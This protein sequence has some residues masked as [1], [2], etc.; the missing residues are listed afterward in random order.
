M[1]PV[2]KIASRY[3]LRFLDKSKLAKHE[4][5]TGD[6]T[7]V[8]LFF[9]IPNGIAERFPPLGGDDGSP[10]HV[11][12]LYVGRVPP[13]Q[14]GRFLKI[15][16]DVFSEWGRP[17]RA[18]H[19]DVTYF[20]HPSEHRRVA[21]LP[22]RFEED[23][24][25]LRWRLRSRLLDNGFAVKDRFP[26]VYRPH[27]TLAYLEGVGST[28]KGGHP[29]GDWV[30]NEAEVWGLP[31]K[32]HR[33]PLGP[34]YPLSNSV[35]S[36]F[37]QG[38]PSGL[39]S[40]SEWARFASEGGGHLRHGA[41]HGCEPPGA[42]DE[43][44]VIN[45]VRGYKQI[46]GVRRIPI[47]KVVDP[48][49]KQTEIVTGLE[50][51]KKRN[52]MIKGKPYLSTKEMDALFSN[53]V[54][55][56]EK[57]D[58]HPVIILYGGYT[59]FC[60]SL[61]I[62]HT[63]EYDACPYSEMGWPDMTVVYDI[64]D[65]EVSPPYQRGQGGNKWLSRSEKEALCRMVGAPLVPL[66]FKGRVN[67]EDVPALADRTSSFGSSTAEGVVIKN[68]HKGVFGKFINLEFQRSISDESLWGQVHPMQRGKKNIR[69]R[70]HG[71]GPSRF[72]W[73]GPGTKIHPSK[74]KVSWRG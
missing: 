65:G 48:R 66:V 33:I 23:L 26:L 20:D 31:G 46:S 69:R 52:L 61:K 44:Q 13:G 70:A 45:Y 1:G 12:F 59:F 24:S 50:E 8:G 14:E 63:V 10:P 34:G 29:G 64:L 71:R 4:S 36:L 39:L 41:N 58:G 30:V 18:H 62:Q 19:G 54:V 3:M 27:T 73:K 57:V 32:V 38:R 60:E 49:T 68:L 2:E 47:A 22:L 43:I 37:S 74:I 40:G 28:W 55:I 17:T 42:P 16:Q 15:C 25:D 7:S 72:P 9:R 35:W 6:G 51:I 5:Q 21:V 53:E 11:T 67:P 56:E